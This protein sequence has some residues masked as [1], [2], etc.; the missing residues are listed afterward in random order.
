MESREIEIKGLKF[1]AYSDGRVFYW[2]NGEYKQIGK[3]HPKRKRGTPYIN[4]TI[5]LGN[6]KTVSLM[7][8][9]VVAMAF[10]PNPL[11]KKCVNHK[12]GN[13][14]NNCVDNLEW[15]TDKENRLHAYGYKDYLQQ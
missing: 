11:N 3:L 7:I 6:R 8:H 1:L 12:D 5:Y 15:V 14:W 10:I 4:T 13:T 9:R 2:K